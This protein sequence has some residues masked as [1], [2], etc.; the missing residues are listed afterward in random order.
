MKISAQVVGDS[1]S[2]Q[3]HRITTMEL[4]FPRFILAE[5]KTHR[6]LSGLLGQV[7]I[8]ESVSLN[9]FQEGSKNSASSRAI[10]FK[11]MVQMVQENPFIP[12]AWQKDHKGM[13]GTEYITDPDVLW[14]ITE[15][16][17]LSMN[18]Q[19][20]RSRM[21]HSLGV[22]KQL[23]N[24]LLEPFMW[25]KVL[26]TGTEFY[27][28]FNLRCPVYE[29]G[30]MLGTFKSWKDLCKAEREAYPEA[31]TYVYNFDND[32]LTRLQRNKGQA[33]IHMMALAEA[34]WDAMNESTPKQLEASEW[35]IPYEDKILHTEQWEI[36]TQEKPND[37]D[38]VKADAIKVS[39]AMCARTSYTTVG[40]EKEISYEKL[41]GI[42]DKMAIA[43]PFHASPFE[44][45]ARVMNEDE[46]EL[47]THEQPMFLD[48]PEGSH[49]TKDYGW[50][51]NFRGF[52]QYRHILENK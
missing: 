43:N 49:V 40:D 24:R 11:K 13:Q 10:P 21:Q 17:K 33:E 18:E 34:M 28:F 48:M 6:I 5:A 47:Y 16:Y 15:N 9:D 25:H 23:C 14:T 37:W 1:L 45:C 26:I 2:P 7:E 12:I 42:H 52:I 4:V 50:C 51:R 38:E 3:K 27:N 35:H 19:I 22:T 31:E 41:I 36:L 30:G 29:P 39:T 20:N 46:Y 44:H 32:L 8:T